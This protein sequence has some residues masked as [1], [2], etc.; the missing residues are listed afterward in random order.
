MNERHHASNAAP[1]RSSILLVFV[2]LSFWK[3]WVS[4]HNP[5]VAATSASINVGSLDSM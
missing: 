1:V 3:L 4:N 2:G 5:Y